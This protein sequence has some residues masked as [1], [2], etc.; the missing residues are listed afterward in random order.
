MGISSSEGHALFLEQGFGS[1]IVYDIKKKSKNFRIKSIIKILFA[2]T[3]TKHYKSHKIAKIRTTTLDKLMNK[4]GRSADL[5]Q[6]DVQGLEVDILNG[7]LHSLHT[8][9]VKTFLIGTHGKD[10]H[11]E[12]LNILKRY[13]YSIEFEDGETKN[14]P[15]GIIIASKNV[16]R[17]QSPNFK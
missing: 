5:V 15:D 7:G 2:Q 14:Q 10:K 11:K 3:G 13:F 17:L 4:I 1:K 6:M 16:K 12:C 8:G 9:N